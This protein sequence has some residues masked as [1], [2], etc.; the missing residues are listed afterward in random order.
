MFSPSSDKMWQWWIVFILVG[1]IRD[2]GIG[3]WVDGAH[4]VAP[5]WAHKGGYT[6]A[7]SSLN[8]SK[9]EVP[10]VVDFLATSTMSDD[11]MLSKSLV[12]N[13][14]MTTSSDR[15][16]HTDLQLH[17]TVAT[18]ID[19]ANLSPT[20]DCSHGHV[21]DI[22]L[23]FLLPAGAFVDE[24]ELESRHQ[25]HDLKSTNGQGN[26]V[27][28]ASAINVHTFHA[29]SNPELMAEMVAAQVDVTVLALELI[30][31]HQD[32]LSPH[33]NRT[34]NDNKDMQ[35]CAGNTT[36]HD[37]SFSIPVH[38]RYHSAD[39]SIKGSDSDSDDH[40]DTT[41]AKVLHY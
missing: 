27:P 29:N 5:T 1:S 16:F 7:K 24:H 6:T 35:Q 36:I 28:M 23:L 38:L 4:I 41:H 10:Y 11:T 37:V 20:I 12:S 25:F 40:T 31:V 19:T 18:P 26:G 17:L 34:D 14:I 8:E 30:G 3:T 15:G 32:S 22:M 39:D 9:W 2:P 33:D 13:L 21:S